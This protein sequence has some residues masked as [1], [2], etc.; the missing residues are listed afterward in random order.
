MGKKKLSVGQ[1]K[2]VQG[3]KTIPETEVLETRR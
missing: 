2:S 1:K 3:S